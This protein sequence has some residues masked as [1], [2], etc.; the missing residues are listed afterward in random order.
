MDVPGDI[1]V[2]GFDDVPVT[3]WTAPAL[4][5]VRQPLQAMAAMVAR[6]LLRLVDGEEVDLPGM[7][8]TTQLV[9]RVSTAP[10]PTDGDGRWRGRPG[11]SPPARRN[12]QVRPHG[13]NV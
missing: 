3:R 10:V 7:E 4:T 13:L 9:V 1:N 8:L 11:P 6:T 5:T 12:P 2:V